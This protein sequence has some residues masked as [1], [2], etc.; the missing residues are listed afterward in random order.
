MRA[1]LVAQ[2]SR[3]CES[4]LGGTG[5][6]PVRKD[7][8]P[9]QARCLF[10]HRARKRAALYQWPERTPGAQSGRRSRQ[11]LAPAADKILKNVRDSV[12]R[13]HVCARKRDFTTEN[14]ERHGGGIVLER[15]SMFSRDRQ[16]ALEG[17]SRAFVCARRE[18]SPSSSAC[19][20]QSGEAWHPA[21]RHLACFAR[22]CEAW[23]PAHRHPHASPK[24]AKHGTRPVVIRHASSTPGLAKHGTRRAQPGTSPRRTRRGTEGEG[25]RTRKESAFK[26]GT[27]S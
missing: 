14:T 11:V 13:G 22:S 24:A 23:H 20:A 17:P 26:F 16:G 10:H 7:E 1:E 19:F 18:D 9:E 5:V 27:G 6:P 4:A 2:A 25:A 3:L 21:R 15:G 12:F 8:D